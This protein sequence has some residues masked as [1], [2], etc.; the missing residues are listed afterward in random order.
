MRADFRAARLKSVHAHEE[1]V[2]KMENDIRDCVAKIQARVHPCAGGGRGSPRC[3][4]FGGARRGVLGLLG[5]G[6]SN[7]LNTYR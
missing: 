5:P 4:A 6:S 2:S 1:Q 7:V 3:V